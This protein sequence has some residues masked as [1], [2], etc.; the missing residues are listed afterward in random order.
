MS[1]ACVGGVGVVMRLGP[2]AMRAGMRWLRRIRRRPNWVHDAIR[3]TTQLGLPRQLSS[4]ELMCL[5]VS[6]FKVNVKI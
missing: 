5:G 4:G 1:R 6:M 3:S 2:L